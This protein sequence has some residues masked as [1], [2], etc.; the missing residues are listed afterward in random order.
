MPLADGHDVGLDAVLL[1]GEERAGA[2]HAALDLVEHQHQAVLVGRAR[3][4]RA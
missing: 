4:G 2:R 1:I 3:A